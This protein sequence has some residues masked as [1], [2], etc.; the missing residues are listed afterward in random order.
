M[1][2]FS[3]LDRKCFARGGYGRVYTGYAR[4]SSEPGATMTRSST[5]PLKVAVKVQR[6]AT[7]RAV[8]RARSEVMFLLKAQGHPNIATFVGLFSLGRAANGDASAKPSESDE[9][10]SP[11]GSDENSVTSNQPLH[12]WSLVMELYPLGDLHS[13]VTSRGGL[14]ERAALEAASC[15]KLHLTVLRSLL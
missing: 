12:N 8:F 13:L 4:S 2:D 15:E 10:P 7:D 5:A 3:R 9:S 6:A 14:P 1:S 11:R